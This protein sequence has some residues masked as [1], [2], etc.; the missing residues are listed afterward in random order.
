M[1]LVDGHDG[2]GRLSFKKKKGINETAQQKVL[3]KFQICFMK[4]RLYGGVG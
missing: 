1:R 4:Q 3:P 2:Q